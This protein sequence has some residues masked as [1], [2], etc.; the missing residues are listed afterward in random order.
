MHTF[1][2]LFCFHLKHIDVKHTPHCAVLGFQTDVLFIHLVLTVVQ[3]KY[4]YNC[5]V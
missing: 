2:F 1:T 4:Y 5:I 3:N